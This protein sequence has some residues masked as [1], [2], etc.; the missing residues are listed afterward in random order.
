MIPPNEEN[1]NFSKIKYMPDG[2]KEV[3]KYITTQPLDKRK[4]G[5]GTK[6]AHRRDEF[7]NAIRTEQYRESINKE[8]RMMAQHAGEKKTLTTNVSSLL[9][10]DLLPLS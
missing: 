1:G 2:Y 4:R 3:N 5:F 8:K 10:F 9:M 6:D 7:A